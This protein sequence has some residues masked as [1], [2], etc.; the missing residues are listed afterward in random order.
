NADVFY[1]QYL[2]SVK[3]TTIRDF[4]F[5]YRNID[6]LIIDD[7]QFISGKMKTQEAFFQIFDSLLLHKKQV[8]ITADKDP[9][10]IV[11]FEDRILNR[12]KWGVCDTLQIPDLETRIAIL[13]KMLEQNGIEF[14]PDVIEYMAIRINTNV[15]EL[16]GAMIAL[17]AQASLN[18]KEITVE[19]ATTMIDK[20]VKASAK[21]I[22]IDYIQKMVSDYFRIPVATIND[23]SR[24]REIVLARQI[25]MYFSKKYTKMPYATIGLHCGKRDHATV[26]YSCRNIENLCDTDK[27]I[28]QYVEDIE[29]KIKI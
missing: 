25:C 20:Y 7:I 12:F 26:L 2:E 24:K 11:G 13:H 14:P 28:K 10:E 5:F 15:R 16:K 27:N 4:I 23:N 8:I 1:Q 29:K 9:S 3:N 22:S 17:I 21:E 18:H 19:L 6:V